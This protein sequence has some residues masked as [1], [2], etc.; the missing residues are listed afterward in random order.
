MRYDEWKR[1]TTKINF[2]QQ[3]PQLKKLTDL[4]QIHERNPTPASV[5]NL[6]LA[7]DA[8]K[9]CPQY[10]TERTQIGI[11][12]VTSLA[13]IAGQS[14]SVL[15]GGGVT[16]RPDGYRLY[17]P[18]DVGYNLDGDVLLPPAQRPPA[19]T[20]AQIQIINEC[21][22][23]CRRA[24]TLSRDA[25]I[26][27]AAKT[28]LGPNP[29]ANEQRY[30]DIFGAFDQAR[31]K[32]VLKNYK[33]IASALTDP[34]VYDHR[35]TTFF[36]GKGE[37]YAAT[38]RGAQTVDVELWLGRDFFLDRARV[39]RTRQDQHNAFQTATDA[40]VGTIVHEFS[41]ASINSVDVPPVD[42]FGNWKLTPDATTWES[43]D[44]DVQASGREEVRRVAAKEPRA[45]IVA[46][47]CYGQF[48]AECL[49]ASGK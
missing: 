4:Y 37:G 32:T 34:K 45:A 31:A 49:A 41:H 6:K 21:M 23:R 7:L 25:M 44:N 5:T 27:V 11:A 1:A 13:Y 40:T 35:H 19:L 22:R 47:D 42:D 3:S 28:A 14:S 24:V 48:A 16:M 10:A 43:P 30:V 18:A 2:F 20:A 29:T 39:G 9:A 26:D 15:P 33:T 38:H 17:G 8:W 12:N 46:A 36:A